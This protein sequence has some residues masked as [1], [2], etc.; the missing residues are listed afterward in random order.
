MAKEFEFRDGFVV[1]RGGYYLTKV[2]WFDE[3]ED[4]MVGNQSLSK[5]VDGRDKGCTTGHLGGVELKYRK[6]A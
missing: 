5:H 4:I 2:V 3:V 1:Y 6:E